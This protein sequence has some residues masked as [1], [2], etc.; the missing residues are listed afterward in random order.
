MNSMMTGRL[1]AGCCALLALVLGGCEDKPAGKAPAGAASAT[2]PG[3][4]RIIPGEP[5]SAD[6]LNVIPAAGVGSYQWYVNDQLLPGMNESRL[7]NDFFARDDRVTVKAGAGAQKNSATVTIGNS[8]PQITGIATTPEEW[9]SGIA[10]EVVP[11]AED[12]DGDVVELRYQWSINGEVDPFL[13]EAVLPAERNR[14]GDRIEVL[15]TPFDGREEGRVYRSVVQA[16]TGSAPTIVSKPPARFEALSY[17][18]QVKATDPD[19]DQ[20]AFSLDT[21]P[22]GMTIEPATGRLSWPLAGVPPGKYDVRIVVRD[23]EG[24]EDRQEYELTLGTPGLAAE[25]SPR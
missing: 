23:P 10:V 13:T 17:E 2:G 18:Y 24:G 8:A 21:P 7:C 11:A 15:V 6:C 22:A 9:H 5:T 4:L 19:N 1:L 12:V 14:R 25:G 20:L 3:T 16:V